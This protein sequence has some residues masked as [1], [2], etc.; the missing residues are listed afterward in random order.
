M[1]MWGLAWPSLGEARLVVSQAVFEPKAVF[2]P[3]AVSGQSS[4]S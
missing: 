4:P 1:R 2:E 3:N